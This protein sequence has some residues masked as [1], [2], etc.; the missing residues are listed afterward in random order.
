MAILRGYFLPFPC[1]T[2]HPMGQHWRRTRYIKRPRDMRSSDASPPKDPEN[3]HRP[4]WNEKWEMENSNRTTRIFQH[5]GS[6]GPSFSSARLLI[7]DLTDVAAP[8]SSFAVLDSPEAP[9]RRTI[10][11]ERSSLGLRVFARTSSGSIFKSAVGRFVWML[12]ASR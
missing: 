8:Q 2:V 4:R 6:A 5:A 7:Q 11:A 1:G 12:R 10:H 3:P 9:N